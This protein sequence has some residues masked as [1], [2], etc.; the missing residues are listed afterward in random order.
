MAS[1]LAKSFSAVKPSKTL[2]LAIAFTCGFSNAAITQEDSPWWKG[3]FDQKSKSCD[4]S[5]SS[6][7][8]PPERVPGTVDPTPLATEGVEESWAGFEELVLANSKPK[9]SRKEGH[10]N[11]VWDK[12]MADLDSTWRT[13]GHPVQ[14]YRVQLFSG[15][16]QAAREFRSTAR[17]S[18][19]YPVYLSA[20]PP[21]YRITLGNFRTKWEAENVKDDWLEAFPLSLVI[22]MAIELPAF[23]QLQD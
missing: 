10:Y 12:R 20:M 3:L 21:N 6:P 19:N 17:K 22:P 15:S 7:V 14:G 13:L 9:Q 5:K 23:P 11:L 16:L 8:A 4:S 1:S 18:S 2:F